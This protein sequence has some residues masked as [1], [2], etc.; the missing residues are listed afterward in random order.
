MKFYTL[1]KLHIYIN[2]QKKFN[3]NL[4]LLVKTKEVLSLQVVLI[5]IIIP[6]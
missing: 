6:I 3:D 4:K 2:F 1:P 5:H